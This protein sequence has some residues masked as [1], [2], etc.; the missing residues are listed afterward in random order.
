MLFSEIPGQEQAKRRLLQLAYQERIAHALLFTGPEGCGHL[1]VAIAFAQYLACSQKQENDSCGKCSSCV[2]CQKLIHP[3]LHFSFPTAIIK[4]RKALSEEFLPKWRDAVLQNPVMGLY[5]WYECLGIENKQGYMSVDESAAIQQKLSL[6]SYESKYKVMVIWMAEKMRADA[7]NK[8]L[9]II[10]E[11]PDNTLF[12]LITENPEQLQGT[13][14]SRM[15]LVKF[16]PLQDE[17]IQKALQAETG[18]EYHEARRIVRLAEGNLNLART[19]A[20][21]ETVSIALEEEFMQWMRMCYALSGGTNGEKTYLDLTRWIDRMAKSG[22]EKL[23][24]FIHYGLEVMRDCVLYNYTGESISRIN[25]DLL[26]GFS[27]FAPFIRYDNAEYF[28]NELSKAH[29]HIERNA[30]P[31]ILF[32]DLSFKINALLHLK[33]S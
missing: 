17:V 29:F 19:L 15:Q 10:E 22:R 2:K 24:K 28:E 7:A 30:N 9:K 1:A 26:P 8:L 11:P 20:G 5:D 16:T 33:K 3:D 13:L 14:L 27:R 25:D 6:K 12:L 23:K 32:I 18:L 31:R 21:Q 4:P